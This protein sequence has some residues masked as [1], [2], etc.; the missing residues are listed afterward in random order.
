M[1]MTADDGAAY[2]HAVAGIVDALVAA[3]EAQQPVNMTRLKNDVAKRYRLPSMPKV[4]GGLLLLVRPCSFLDQCRLTATDWP[5]AAR[6]HHLGRAGRLPRQA[7]A[8]PARQARA[9]RVGHRCRRTTRTIDG[10]A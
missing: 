9:H 3:Y 8:L 1:A 7:P 2:V 4:S 6:G 5:A 10:Y